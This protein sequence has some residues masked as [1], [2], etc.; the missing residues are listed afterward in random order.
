MVLPV[1]DPDHEF[2]KLTQI[3]IFFLLIF[4]FNFTFDTIVFKRLVCA[5]LQFLFYQVRSGPQVL[6]VKQVGSPLITLITCLSWYLRLTRAD[7]FCLFFLSKLMFPKVFFSKLSWR[8]P[9]PFIYINYSRF[10]ELKNTLKNPAYP[11]FLRK[12]IYNSRQSVD[13]ITNQY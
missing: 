7:C 6:W 10:I 4:F 9:P 12:Q 2:E 3:N 11:I 8:L 1:H 5:F 13:Q